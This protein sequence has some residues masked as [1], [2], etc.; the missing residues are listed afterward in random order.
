[1]INETCNCSISAVANFAGIVAHGAIDMM[2]KYNLAVIIFAILGFMA[3]IANVGG[4]LFKALK[5]FF[6]IFVAIPIIIIFGL[7]NKKERA[8][9]LKD[10]GEIKA[11][12]KENPV[13][14]KLF[15]YKGLIFLFIILVSILIIFFTKQFLLPVYELAG[16]SENLTVNGF[17][18]S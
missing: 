16:I 13:K 18:K 6:M 2:D 17:K 7:I 4:H 1:M 5:Y 3:I 12:L 15:I 11:Y 10:L 9:R 8:E 14:W